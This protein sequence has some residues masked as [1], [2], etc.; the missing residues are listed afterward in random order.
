M[1]LSDRPQ[2]SAGFPFRAPVCR[3]SRDEASFGE[4]PYGMVC[5][6]RPTAVA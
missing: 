4:Y 5:Q 3:F 1:T 6:P 2:D